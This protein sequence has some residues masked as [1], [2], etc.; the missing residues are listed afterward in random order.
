MIITAF[1]QNLNC[2]SNGIDAMGF[3]HQTN[4]NGMGW[5]EARQHLPVCNVQNLWTM[6]M[7]ST[8]TNASVWSVR[9]GRRFWKTETVRCTADW[10]W[11]SVVTHDTPQKHS[12]F[13]ERLGY[14]GFMMA[15]H[16]ISLLWS[17]WHWAKADGDTWR[18]V[19]W[20]A[21]C[22]TKNGYYCHVYLHCTQRSLLCSAL[23]ILFGCC[24][25]VRL[26]AMQLALWILWCYRQTVH[27]GDLYGLRYKYMLNLC[28]CLRCMGGRDIWVLIGHLFIGC[29]CCVCVFNGRGY[30]SEKEIQKKCVPWSVEPYQCSPT[31]LDYANSI[32]SH[33]LSFIQQ[34]LYICKPS[35][36]K[37]VWPIWLNAIPLCTN[38]LDTG[39][40]ITWPKSHLSTNIE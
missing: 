19:V 37:T 4:N 33:C 10:Q 22:I 16:A 20:H 7:R 11:S 30:A 28:Y 12:E 15:E 17:L 18:A 21:A 14:Q 27:D 13:A 3:V 29:Y 24:G 2:Q 40:A 31:E 38:A 23:Y 6:R 36:I 26:C 25:C 34:I 9:S 5:Y 8:N 35:D 1:G 39:W 32:L